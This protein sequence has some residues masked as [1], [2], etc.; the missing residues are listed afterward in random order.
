[1]STRFVLSTAFTSCLLAFTIGRSARMILME[2][3][4][5]AHADGGGDERRSGVLPAPVLQ[6]GKTM[7]RTIYTSKNFDTASSTASSLLIEQA[8]PGRNETTSV[9]KEW[10][11]HEDQATCGAGDACSRGKE[12]LSS[13]SSSSPADDS[14]IAGDDEEHLPA[15]QHLL[16]DIKNVD[17]SF[18]NDES[19][20][21]QAMIDVVNDSQLTL[22]S[23][24]CHG[25]IPEGVS[26]AGVL[27]ESHV[28]F[29]TWPGEGVITLDLFT[30]GL[31]PLL[32]VVPI[33]TRVFGVP[34]EIPGSDPPSVLWAHKLRGFRNPTRRKGHLDSWDLGTRVIGVMDFDMK[35]EVAVVQTPFQRIDIY[36]LIFP[37]FNTLSWYDQS[38]SNDG[39]YYAN[40]PVHYLPD[41]Q[42]Y[43][44]GVLQSSRLGD[45][46][47]HEGIVHPAMLAH[48]NPRRVAIIG[49]GEGASLRE[50]LK[51]ESLETVTMIEIDELMVQ[52]SRQYIPTWNTCGDIETSVASCFE[53]PRTEMFYEDALAFFIDRYF[54]DKG[55]KKYDV[56]IMDALDPRDNIE[57]ADQLY[58]N[59][60]FMK[61]LYNAINDDG[62]VAMQLGEAP[63]SIDPAEELS[64]DK[65]RATV[66][67]SMER[68]GFQ[69]FH[70]YEEF[71]SNFLAPWTNI[72][73]C[74]D[75][76]CRKNWNRSPSSI[77][78]AIAKR[79]LPTVSG[80]PPLK[81]FDGPTMALYQ[82]PHKAF[83]TVYCRNDP[84]PQS[85]QKSGATATASL[86]Q[87]EVRVDTGR[88]H[89]KVDIAR[90]VE[91]GG[92]VTAMAQ[93]QDCQN[94]TVNVVL[95]RLENKH[96]NP[97]LDRNTELRSYYALRDIVAGE[98]LVMCG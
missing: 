31:G 20:L 82:V 78:L 53:D 12:G 43:L 40:N 19:R 61:S 72:V 46:A 51:H 18:L 80:Q 79:L 86:D 49:G 66:I 54:E 59:D 67:Q 30:C 60:V 93:K 22:L 81:H 4:R 65:N 10:T 69:S 84:T 47:Y 52:T 90:G 26:C 13:S 63:L 98:E 68:T 48:P 25:L 2:G 17:G 16:I 29:H 28:A 96:Y 24:H 73:V 58:N 45:E 32:P 50:V 89:T 71:H 33:V 41:R 5:H 87:L 57:F 92:M 97:A 21:A 36:D 38:L 44:D 85:C 64:V 14:T 42:I 15:G 8:R 7:P 95:H 39:S 1:M 37:R 55:E 23:Y 94:N 35:K 56:V 74:K 76:A 62:I 88:L 27:L 11:H 77:D 6:E 34:S 70:M 83:E 75:V 9:H 91:L 3:P